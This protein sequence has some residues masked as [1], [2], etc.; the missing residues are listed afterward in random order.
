MLA[1]GLEGMGYYLLCAIVGLVI[2]GM[3]ANEWLRLGSDRFRRIAL[4]GLVVFSG[5]LIGAV[6][7]VSTGSERAVA[8]QEWVLESLILVA[9]LWALLLGDLVERR[10]ASRFLIVSVAAVVG[11]LLL[12]IFL[13]DRTSPA[14]PRAVWS[15]PLLLSLLGLVQWFRQ[16]QRFSL[17]LGSAFLVSSLS[18]I[19]GL[20]GAVQAAML[21]HLATLV[22]VALETYG[23]VLAGIRGLDGQVRASR[24][25]AWQRTQEIAF[26]LAVSRTLSDSL[27]LRVVL[28]RISEAVARAVNADWA[29]VLM[30]VGQD[31]EKLVVA[32]RY[33]WWGR[34]WTQDSHPS[35]RMEIEANELSLI[36]HAILRRRSV[37]ANAPEDYEQFECL[38]DRFAR[39]Q[40]GPALIQPITHQ[41]RTLGV[42]LL[43][44]VDLSPRESS[45]PDRAFTE[46]DA[47][48]C[49]DLMVHIATAIQNAHLYQSA[50]DRVDREAELRRLQESEALRLYS[51]LDAIA[52]GVMV[53]TE[54]G[55]VVLVNAAAE[56]IL[57]VPRQHILGRIIAPLSAALHRD[58]QGGPA[59]R[60]FFKWDNK[61]L[62]GRQAPVRQPDGKLLGDVVILRDVTSEQHTE[63]A[64]AGYHQAFSSDLEDLLA[65]IQADAQR[66]AESMEGS[67]AELQQRLLGVVGANLVQATTL[68]RD[69]Q[70]LAALKDDTIQVEA[71]PV[72]LGAIVDQVVGTLHSEVE[73]GNLEVVVDLPAKLRPA[74]GDP[75][76]M[77][78]IVFN[79]LHHA[80]RRTPEGGTIDVWATEASVQQGDGDSEDVLVV[81]IRDHGPIIPQMQ[82]EHLFDLVHPGDGGSEIGSAIGRVGL[83]ISKG[84]VAAQ[85]GQLSVT[86]QPDEGS[87]F[88]FSI[89]AA[90]AE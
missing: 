8:Y 31:E 50:L 74:W 86:S 77:W 64:I 19:A 65:A 33:G 40:S 54:T 83:M 22:L 1:Q 10:W 38:H 16:R 25:Q 46:A 21:G 28:E 26:L 66:L 20:A 12:G 4:G 13:G 80:V 42:L 63:A 52:D 76:H 48:L 41:D 44:R 32:A 51:F 14:V 49:Q 53:I 68:V 23:A 78:Q 17:W 84:L 73:A 3:A 2:F 29:Y 85:G 6:V 75:R 88:S 11:A 71:Q 47:Q 9:V 61:Q 27:E 56:R 72:D 79:L 58:E 62:V 55:N 57:N 70:A 67:E 59:D 7:L 37:L 15:L 43:G 45:S 81:S 35:R 5:R 69:F 24:T 60:V 89:P 36:R 18:A 39:P 30:P 34:R 82:Q 90:Q 87:T